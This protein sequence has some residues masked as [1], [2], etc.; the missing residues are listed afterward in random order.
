MRFQKTIFSP[1]EIEYLK[2]N[3]DC[4]PINQ[5]SID[6]AKSRNAI[7][8]KILE[9]EGKPVKLAKK[10]KVSYIGK[11]P[12]LGISCRSSWEANILRYLNSQNIKWLYEPK[13][14]VFEKERKGAISYLPDIYL[15]ELDI[16]VE[17]K[18][19]LTSRDRGTIRKFKK[20]YPNE[21][22]KL[23]VI[24]GGPTTKASKFFIQL[25]V[26]IMCYYADLNKQYKNI[27]KNWE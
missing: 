6:L 17:V 5:L 19:M 9:L 22:S 18:G 15:P 11:R 13:V 25:G 21:F 12:D 1:V 3:K 10:N 20:Y 16:W 7:K 8:N 26:P 24:T 23:K 27:I 4:Q 2:K 14:F